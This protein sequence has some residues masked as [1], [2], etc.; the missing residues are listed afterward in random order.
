MTS[1]FKRHKGLTLHKFWGRRADRRWGA[2]HLICARSGDV[3]LTRL[4][5]LGLMCSALALGACGR[6]GPLEPPP[7]Y[8]KSEDDTSIL[9]PLIDP[10][11][12]SD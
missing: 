6:A 11:F 8:E 3:Q 4:A 1:V 12:P 10:P 9:D 7:D 5:I 2:E